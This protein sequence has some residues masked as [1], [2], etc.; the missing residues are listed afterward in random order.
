LNAL[1]TEGIMTKI[2]KPSAK[3]MRGRVMLMLMRTFEK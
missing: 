2:E 3:E 1:K